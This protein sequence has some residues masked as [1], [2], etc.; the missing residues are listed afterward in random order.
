MTSKGGAAGS[1]SGRR[2]VF[3]EKRKEANDLSF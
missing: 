3:G 2:P 1:A